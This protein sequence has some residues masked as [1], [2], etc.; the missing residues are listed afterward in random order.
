ME[1]RRRDREL[2]V[3]SLRERVEEL[4]RDRERMRSALENT[5]EKLI[6]YKE[7]LQQVEKEKH[8]RTEVRTC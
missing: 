4:G 7:R 1:I 3:F 8:S 5:E 6:E 2:E